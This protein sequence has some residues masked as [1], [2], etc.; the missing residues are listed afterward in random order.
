MFK[1]VLPLSIVIALRFLGLFI[2]M[3]VLSIY[4]LKL[5]HSTEI[6]VGVAIGIYAIS[7]MAMQIPLGSLSD[8]IGRKQVIIFGTFVFIAGSLIC[9][10]A[11][12][13]Y[14]LLIGRFVQGMGA[15][16]AVGT[17]LI[18]DLISEERR[19]KAM[20]IMGATIALSFAFSMVLGPIIGGF[21]G[22]DKLF[23]LTAF[24][25]L[26]SLLLLIKVPNPPHIQSTTQEVK[27]KYKTILKD[28]NLFRMNITNFLQKALM[29]M[30]FL[31]IPLIMEKTFFWQKEE[32]WRVYLP[33]MIFGL[34]AMFL[35]VR[36]GELKNK[37]KEMIFI[38]IVLFLVAYVVMG[39]ANSAFVFV[40]GVVIFFIGFNIHEPLMQSLASKYA[41]ANERGASL[42]VFNT[43]GYFGTFIGGIFG[44]FF[45]KYYG[46][47]QI[48][49]GVFF[50]C[51]IWLGFILTLKN[52]A[53]R[54]NVYIDLKNVDFSRIDYLNGARG[55]LEWYINKSE[56][57]LV[58]KYDSTATDDEMILSIVRA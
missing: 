42:G 39:Y 37:S 4:A 19:T 11:T 56:N 10:F 57:L 28:A 41:K 54:K 22:V 45:M 25:A 32:L 5:E 33:A 43:F 16:G 17:A 52:P 51:I 47:M 2:V 29:T 46:I 27:V 20:A 12:D 7:Q 14:S 30:A 55:I 48:S 35:A 3:P 38:G 49:W 26:L 18:T 23:F 40:A 34:F 1:T 6:L 21:F 8:K 9:A 44:G 31:S 13:I 36:F 24:L 15:I 58:V 53:F 50:L